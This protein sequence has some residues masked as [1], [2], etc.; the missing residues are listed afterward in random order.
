MG[1]KRDLWHAFKDAASTAAAYEVLKEAAKPNQTTVFIQ[2]TPPPPPM[3]PTVYEQHIQQQPGVYSTPVR[4]IYRDQTPPRVVVV[5]QTTTTA[6]DWL[7][8]WCA[9][10]GVSIFK[11]NNLKRNMAA[12]GWS[13][14]DSE[15]DLKTGTGLR[16]YWRRGEFEL[17]LKIKHGSAEVRVERWEFDTTIATMV[18]G[19]VTYAGGVTGFFRPRAA[20]GWNSVSSYNQQM[21]GLMFDVVNTSLQ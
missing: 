21:I 13:F 17:R 16:L 12:N 15:S 8:D 1:I 18:G 9:E 6:S 7:G 11:I 19:S 14:R 4:P 2:Q 3:R 5:Q 10:H 20:D